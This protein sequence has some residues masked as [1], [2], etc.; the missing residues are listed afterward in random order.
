MRESGFNQVDAGLGSAKGGV[1]RQRDVRQSRERMPRR[2]RLD[3]EDVQSSVRD[4]ARIQRV[5]QRSLVEQR[6]AGGV[7]DDGAMSHRRDPL[8]RQ[9]ASCLIGERQ[10]K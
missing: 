6:A 5:D 7:D 10:V 9:K 2:Q 1:G 3:G 4:L 8:T